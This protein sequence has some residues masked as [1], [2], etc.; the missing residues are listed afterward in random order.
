MSGTTKGYDSR[1]PPMAE[2]EEHTVRT[3]S[4]KRRLDAIEAKMPVRDDGPIV[5]RLRSAPG[6]SFTRRGL[7]DWARNTPPMPGVTHPIRG[8]LASVYLHAMSPDDG[9][10]ADPLRK[11]VAPADE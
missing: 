7:S 2:G 8:L 3:T 6:L 1:M 4:W 10:G 11:T 5:V 9:P